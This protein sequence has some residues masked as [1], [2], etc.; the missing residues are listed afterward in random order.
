MVTPGLPHQPQQPAV[1][2]KP[3]ASHALLRKPFEKRTVSEP[4]A[5]TGA[6]CRFEPVRGTGD[7]EV[8]RLAE[9]QHGH[10]HL[11][12][13]R[14]AALG[15]HAVA[16][17]VKTGGLRRVFPS[18][19]SVGHAETEFLGRAMASVLHFKGD[20][21]ASA[22]CAAELWDFL[23]TTQRGHPRRAIDVLLVGRNADAVP[24][25]RIHRVKAIARQDVRWRHGIP[26]TSPARACL[27]LAAIFDDFELEAALAAAFRRNAV[28]PSQIEDV[29]ARNPQAKGVGRL[30]AL[31]DY[32][33]RPH[34]TRS[35]YER[36][37]L[38]LIRAAELPT[39]LT[40]AYIGEHMVDMLWPELKLVVE[41]DSWAFHG[42]RSSFEKDRLRDQVLSVSGHH[43]MR[44]TARQVDHT[45]TALV[46]R[47]A[48]IITA[49]QLSR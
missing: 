34:D 5:L 44:V 14:A 47:I 37:L 38:A 32:A 35:D 31:L 19:Y 36:R 2:D 43:V 33:G 16:H 25:V 21:L 39:P 24:G 6:V 8:M 13:L 10:L 27:D 30:R 45:P 46:A 15:R 23:D 40:N 17:R 11:H 4:P 42:D 28:R 20:A 18:V 41:F 26:V 3:H 9:L 22:L 12:Q 48:A 7:A 1:P 49:R 29:M